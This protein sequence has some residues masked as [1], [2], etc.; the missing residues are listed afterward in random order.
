MALH[1]IA[2]DTAKGRNKRIPTEYAAGGYVD[3]DFVVSSD[4]GQIDFVVVG[5][6]VTVD[7]KISCF[8]NGVQYREGVST[9][10]WQRNTGANKIVFNASVRKHGVVRVRLYS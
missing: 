8:V 4:L 9:E 7:G 1:L 2:W 10:Q 3:Y 5:G 6:T